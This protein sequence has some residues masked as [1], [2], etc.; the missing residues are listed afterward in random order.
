MNDFEWD[1][2]KAL[3]NL[4]KHG[5]DFADAATSFDDPRALTI[6][7]PDASGEERFLCLGS[8]ITGEVLVT[9]FTWRGETIRIIT[10][11]RASR[12]ERTR[13]LAG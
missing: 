7:D 12:R 6:R 13:Y 5:V 11:R 3:G 2:A 8:D 9:V 1:P 4:R 10:A